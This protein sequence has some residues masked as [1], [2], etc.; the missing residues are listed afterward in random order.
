MTIN[1]TLIE[2]FLIFLRVKKLKKG[3]NKEDKAK[4]IQSQ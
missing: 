1:S 2:C 3:K 4:S